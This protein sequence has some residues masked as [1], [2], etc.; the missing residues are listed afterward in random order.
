MWIVVPLISL[1]IYL[2]LA[3]WGGYTDPQR[4]HGR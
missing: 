3:Y 2:S 1:A 4:K